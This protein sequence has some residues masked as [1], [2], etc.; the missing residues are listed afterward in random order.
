MREYI[1]LILALSVLTAMGECLLPEGHLRRF[2]TPLL[3]L[4]VSCA[5][6]LPV[7]SAVGNPDGLSTLLPAAEAALEGELYTESVTNEY[8]KRLAG[9]IE[10]RGAHAEIILGDDFSVERVILEGDVPHEA[11]QYILFTM[12][13]PRSHVEIR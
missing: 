4:F 1:L 6:L 11:M 2:V 8:K 10:K 5:V 9:E 7:L 12:E 3:G 13:V